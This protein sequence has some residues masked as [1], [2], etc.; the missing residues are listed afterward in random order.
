M[1]PTG[2]EQ[3]QELPGFPHGTA[4]DDALSDAR[5]GDSR[6]MA[7][8]EAWAGLPDDVKDRIAAFVESF[9]GCPRPPRGA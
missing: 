5:W 1:P 9:A 7:L 8:V 2:V 3:S 6:L 4:Q